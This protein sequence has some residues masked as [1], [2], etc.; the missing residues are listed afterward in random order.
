MRVCQPGEA[1]PLKAAVHAAIGACA[2][3]AWAYNVWA[4]GQRR[5]PHLLLNSGVY[6]VLTAWELARVRQHLDRS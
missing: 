5:D 2:L 4:Y 1:E 6:G 3:V